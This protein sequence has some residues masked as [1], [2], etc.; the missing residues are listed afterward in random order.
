V[1]TRKIRAEGD[2]GDL[3]AVRSSKSHL[4]KVNDLKLRK[5]S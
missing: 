3:K 1:K 4:N 5:R 2:F